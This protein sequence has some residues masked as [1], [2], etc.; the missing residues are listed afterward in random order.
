MAQYSFG[1]RI[2]VGKLP[3]RLRWGLLEETCRLFSEHRLGAAQRDEVHPC[4]FLDRP[5]LKLFG[6]RHGFCLQGF[7]RD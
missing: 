7:V 4:K 6:E 3:S 1:Q 2:G 5:L